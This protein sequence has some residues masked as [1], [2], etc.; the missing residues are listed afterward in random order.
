[1]LGKINVRVFFAIDKRKLHGVD[2]RAIV[3]LGTIKKESEGK[4]PEGDKIRI[5]RRLRKYLAGDYG[6][7]PL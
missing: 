6:P 5:G 4:T 3:V 7:L 2:H 1:M